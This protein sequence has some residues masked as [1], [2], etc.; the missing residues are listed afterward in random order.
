LV[1]THH[2]RLKHVYQMT[3]PPW[4]T[5]QWF[6][7]KRLMHQL[8]DKVGVD[9]AKTYYPANRDAISSWDLP[10]PVILKPAC[11]DHLNKLTADKAWRADNLDALLSRYDQA[12]KL[13]PPEM[14]MIQEL[15]PGGGESQFSYAALCKEGL[16]VA[17]VVARRTRQFPMDF[18]RASTFVETIDDP[19][20]AGP[21]NRVLKEMG[22]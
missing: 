14:L 8:A 7:D 2:E 18:G 21:A 4:E 6:V 9:H 3:V 11:R 5:L 20:I 17:S 16:S 12:C 10:F 15:I 22:Y 1:A 19:G 13:L